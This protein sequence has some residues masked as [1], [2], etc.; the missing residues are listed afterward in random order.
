MD[1]DIIY[2]KSFKKWFGDWE[3]DPDHSSKMV[4]KEGRPLICY[5]GS[6]EKF[7]EFKHKYHWNDSGYFG[8]G[9]YFTFSDYGELSKEEAKF[10]GPIIYECYLNI[11]NPFDFSQ[12]YLRD[13]EK[14]DVDLALYNLYLTFPE[15]DPYIKIDC[16][17]KEIGLKEYGKLYEDIESKMYIDRL[18]DERYVWRLKRKDLGEDEEDYYGWT[19]YD[20]EEEAKKEKLFWIKTFLIEYDELYLY[21]FS[22]YILQSSDIFSEL[23][24]RKGY[25]GIIQSRQGDEAVVFYPNQIKSAINNNGNFSKESDNIYEKILHKNNK[26][27]VTDHTAKKNLG[28][29]DTKE[30]AKKRLRQVEYFK[31]KNES[32]KTM[33]NYTQ[34]FDKYTEKTVKINNAVYQANLVNAVTSYLKSNGYQATNNAIATGCEELKKVFKNENT[35]TGY[36]SSYG[37]NSTNTSRINNVLATIFPPN[38]PQNDLINDLAGITILTKDELRAMASNGPISKVMA[39]LMKGKISINSDKKSKNIIKKVIKGVN[40][41]KNSVSN[42]KANIDNFVSDSIHPE[43]KVS[44]IQIIGTDNVYIDDTDTRSRK[45]SNKKSNTSNNVRK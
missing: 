11:R 42:I 45:S 1:Q 41:T 16:N 21:K 7:C 28:T 24:K 8:K 14:G 26:W 40:D 9:F 31:H 33:N 36:A 27:I 18:V 10:Y 29:Y 38:S 3:N 43:I 32:K 34:F 25:D 15:L 30:E 23:I 2:S 17:G 22:Y 20:T 12:F 39:S 19:Q 4:D 37:T 6:H 44:N 5:H 35:A 13:G